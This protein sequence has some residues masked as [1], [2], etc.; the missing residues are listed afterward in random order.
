MQKALMTVAGG[1]NCCFS[2]DSRSS[3]STHDFRINL[4]P[5]MDLSGSDRWE[6]CLEDLATWYTWYNVSSDY[7]TNTFKY[8]TGSDWTTI[9]LAEGIY[10]ASD[11]IAAIA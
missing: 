3:G 10:K 6:M 9:T 2:S 4:S 5:S 8:S 7:G 1:F 11:L